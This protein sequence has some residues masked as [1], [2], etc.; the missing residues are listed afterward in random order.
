MRKHKEFVTAFWN[1]AAASLPAAVRKR[2]LPQLKAAEGFELALDRAIQFF[3]R[4]TAH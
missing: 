3:T 2:Y 1:R 4:R